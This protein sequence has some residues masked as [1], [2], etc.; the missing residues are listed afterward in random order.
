MSKSFH[1]A[2]IYYYASSSSFLPFIIY[3]TF[4][5]LH[6]MLMLPARHVAHYY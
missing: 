6:M 3:Y 1:D 5:P 2:T 4:S